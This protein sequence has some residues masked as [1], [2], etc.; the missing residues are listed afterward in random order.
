[1]AYITEFE[2][3]DLVGRR[4][5]FRQRLNRDVNV[6]FG[7]NGSGKT[8]LLKILHAAMLNETRP[9][10]GV[11]FGEASV[12]IYAEDEQRDY[13]ATFDK[14]K[15]QLDLYDPDMVVAGAW[16]E[17]SRHRVPRGDAG[18]SIK[19]ERKQPSRGWSH[20]YLPT[21]RLYAGA[22][23]AAWRGREVRERITS[24]EELEAVLAEFLDRLWASYSARIL[25][26]AKRVQEQGLNSILRSVLSKKPKRVG[27]ELDP[28]EA[29][30]RAV[31]FLGDT[32]GKIDRKSV[33]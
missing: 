12:S 10:H 16:V 1:M 19:P 28:E 30:R 9:L 21:S 15:H 29:Y 6:F 4:G 31:K 5:A 13:R 11:A 26:A 25:G 20:R 27:T 22:D 8:S 24:E 32:A 3:T 2:V 7:L 14:S 33:V 18:W 17:V 23:L